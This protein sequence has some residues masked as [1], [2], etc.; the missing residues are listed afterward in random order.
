MQGWFSV[1]RGQGNIEMVRIYTVKSGALSFTIENCS[2][3]FPQR[4]RIG[5]G[6]M[7]VIGK[8]NGSHRAAIFGHFTVVCIILA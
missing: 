1:S 6:S 5:L 7:N 8:K 4:G 2:S 3:W